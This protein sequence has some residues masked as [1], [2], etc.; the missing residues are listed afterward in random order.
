[1]DTKTLFQKIFGINPDS[2]EV[3]QRLMEVSR[4]YPYFIAPYFF[5]SKI[6]PSSK[7]GI[8]S[9][10]FFHS[11]INFYYA[12]KENAPVPDYPYINTHSKSISVTEGILDESNTP[13]TE[14]SNQISSEPSP[15]TNTFSYVKME[16]KQQDALNQPS[17]PVSPSGFKT[18]DSNMEVKQGIELQEI[19]IAKQDEPIE[20]A[21]K[22]KFTSTKKQPKGEELLFEP[23]HTS[24]YFA[25]QGIKL[26]EEVSPGDRLGTQLKSFTEWLKTMKRVPGR[27]NSSGIELDTPFDNQ[28]E[29]LAE[30]SNVEEQIITESMAEAYIMQGKKQKAI[31]IYEKLSLQNPAKSS[32]FAAKIAGISRGDNLA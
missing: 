27:V 3:E 15:K 22:D 10:L 4:K 25:S 17:T 16:V 24:D 32:F 9:E 31:E 8:L 2:S 5:N 6:N 1:M 20:D 18:E 19:N 28:V 11:P 12:F 26:S 13:I 30:K 7:S 21:E 23:L 14:H 29:K